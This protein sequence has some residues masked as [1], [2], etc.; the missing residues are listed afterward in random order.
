MNTKQFFLTAT[1]LV[2]GLA[3]AAVPADVLSPAPATSAHANST[4]VAEEDKPG[5]SVSDSSL[6]EIQVTGYRASLDAARLLKKNSAE[7]IEA[8]SPE[9]LGKF[10]DNSIAD[11]L[12]RVPGVQIDRD[13]D[14]R[15]GDHVSIRGIGAEF[16]TTTVNGRT[17]G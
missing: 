3:T 17:P 2:C 8:I 12:Q 11:A 15:S 4:V 7:V 9:D 16:I 1:G 13:T 14:G 5:G 10:S 6:E